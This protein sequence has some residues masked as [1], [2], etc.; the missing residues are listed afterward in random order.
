ML[1]K[2]TRSLLEREILEGEELDILIA[3]EELPPLV[4][5]IKPEATA[6]ESEAPQAET[7][8]ALPQDEGRVEPEP[9][10]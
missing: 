8:R 10:V 1:N 3:G 9:A 4:P 6:V 2:V 5:K 7:E